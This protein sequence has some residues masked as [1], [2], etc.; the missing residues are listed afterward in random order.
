MASAAPSVSS[1]VAKSIPPKDLDKYREEFSRIDAD[2][3]GRVDAAELADAAAALGNKLSNTQVKALVAQAD[4]DDD[5]KISFDE[6]AKL[7][8]AA[9][10]S[11][12]SE[13]LMFVK[14]EGTAHSFS[15]EV[16]TFQPT[17]HPP[18][19]TLALHPTPLTN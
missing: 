3:S 12:K 10:A 1:D 18:H 9:K 8:A 13:H 14:G 6:F 5:G 19:C 17:N 16:C 2:N 4:L 11:G 15:R 7:M